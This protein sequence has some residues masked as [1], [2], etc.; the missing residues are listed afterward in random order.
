VG[1]S[2]Q[3]HE[4]LHILPSGDSLLPPVW[5]PIMRQQGVNSCTYAS[6]SANPPIADTPQSQIWTAYLDSSSSRIFQ[7]PIARYYVVPCRY[8]TYLPILW[9]LIFANLSI[10]RIAF[11]DRFSI[12]RKDATTEIS[13]SANTRVPLHR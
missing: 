12:S 11:C 13:T 4:T 1:L 10:S 2:V 6:S 7:S 5:S 8:T 3:R 9:R